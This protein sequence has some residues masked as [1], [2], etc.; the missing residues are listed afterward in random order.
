MDSSWGKWCGFGHNMGSKY[1]V[2]MKRVKSSFE[3]LLKNSM[4]NITRVSIVYTFTFYMALTL[5]FE[6]LHLL[7]FWTTTVRNSCPRY[8]FLVW[9]LFF[10]CGKLECSREMCSWHYIFGFLSNL[11]RMPSP[12]IRDSLV[13]NVID[14][15]CLDF[16]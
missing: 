11:L 1:F 16:V 12:N 2:G 10:F 5:L 15:T 14:T 7:H 6:I 9:K 13:L 3:N 4:T 8:T